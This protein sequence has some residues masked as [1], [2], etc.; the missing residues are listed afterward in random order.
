MHLTC[1]AEAGALVSLSD[2]SVVSEVSVDSGLLF[3]FPD[4]ALACFAAV[5]FTVFL[6]QEPGVTGDLLSSGL[7]SGEFCTA[8]LIYKE[9]FKKMFLV[10]QG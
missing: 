6:A 8:A 7:L 2:E 4:F 1:D 9:R 10:L 3:A 5:T